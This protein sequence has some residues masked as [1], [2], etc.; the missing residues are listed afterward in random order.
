MIMMIFSLV[1]LRE[2]CVAVW[3]LQ[4]GPICS[5]VIFTVIVLNVAAD[6]QSVISIKLLT[7]D[8]TLCHG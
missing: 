8:V 1:F 5:N 4:L 7:C 2:V 6:L 3:S